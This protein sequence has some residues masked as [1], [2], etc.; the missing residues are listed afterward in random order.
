MA[1]AVIYARYSSERQR[2]ESIE[3]QIRV[4]TAEAEAQGDRLVGVYADR[5]LTGTT[6][7]QRAEFLRMVSDAARGGFSKVYVYKLDRFARNRFDSA[8]YRRELQRHGVALVPV[9]EHIPE[10][11]EGIILESL[12][13]GMAEYYSANLS[14]N[15]RRGLEGNALKCMHNG[16]KVLGYRN[17][18]DGR[19]EVDGE[20]AALVR[21]IF[22][23][24]AQ[25]M[26]LGMIAEELDAA[27]ERTIFGKR[28]TPAFI[29]RILH[30][31]KYIGTYRFRE[32][33]VEGGMPRIIDDALWDAVQSRLGAIHMR[34][35]G[36]G[37]C[38]DPYILTGKLFDREGRP[39]RGESGRGRSGRKYC[40]YQCAETGDAVRKDLIEGVVAEA[41]S[42]L[43]S[44]GSELSEEL[45]DSI[46]ACQDES[47]ER[48]LQDMERIRKRIESVEKG[49]GRLVDLVAEGVDPARTAGK[50]G[51]LEEERAALQAE[52]RELERRCPRLTRE[53]VEF[54]LI[55]LLEGDAPLPVVEG[56]V[57]RVVIGGGD[58]PDDDPDGGGPGGGRG[59]TVYFTVSAGGGLYRIGSP[60]P[61]HARSGPPSC[62]P[63]SFA[64]KSAG[65]SRGRSRIPPCR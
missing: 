19:Y 37:R 5:A 42:D 58:G 41:V 34:S 9:A 20:K 31:D 52:L 29:S 24:Y 64:P 33:E 49:I 35:P 1:D 54:F 21:G 59:V 48:D 63:F 55:K 3:D 4:C 16:V 62:G 51:D 44:S 46:L 30:N 25:G 45:A 26:S 65:R 15:V 13:E 53:M 60:N 18:P 61:S 27:G 2:D 43:L 39:Y 36:R 11:P 57:S 50:I 22:E 17:M 28:Y 12:M 7:Q 38:P 40:Y 6:S 32:V 56:F 8:I 14:Q 10:G 47:D 23:M